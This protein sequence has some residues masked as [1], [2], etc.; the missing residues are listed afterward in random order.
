MAAIVKPRINPS[1]VPGEGNPSGCPSKCKR[2]VRGTLDEYLE[3]AEQKLSTGSYTHLRSRRNSE[4]SKAN[5]KNLRRLSS[6]V[7]QLE[8]EVEDLFSEIDALR[9]L[10]VEPPQSVNTDDEAEASL[11]ALGSSCLHGLDFPTSVPD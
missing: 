7:S 3:H 1:P 2:I 8:K 5:L 9:A 10:I 11:R 4:R 6:R